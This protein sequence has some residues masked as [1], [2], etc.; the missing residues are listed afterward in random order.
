MFDEMGND[1]R[2]FIKGKDG[3]VTLLS[4]K[5]CE[6][7]VEYEKPKE[8]KRIYFAAPLF[9][10]SEIMYNHFA[11]NNI[12]KKFGDE[13]EIYLPQENTGINDKRQYADSIMIA[14]GD[15]E[16]LEKA[17]ILIAVIDG[18]SPDVGV[19]AEV[20]YFYS[21]NKPIIAIY[22]DSRQGTY[23]NQQKIDA[24]DD[25]AESQFS[26]VNLYLIGLIKQRGEIV[27]GYE[28]LLKVLPDYV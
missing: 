8:P 13:V 1:M 16:H 15:N 6:F 7:T 27:R 4:D 17:D 19:A 18:Q 3:S 5:V 2:L 20:G 23:D 12:R 26:Y 14:N 10:E 21:M 28:E 11:V 25:I 24:L 22:S 9:S